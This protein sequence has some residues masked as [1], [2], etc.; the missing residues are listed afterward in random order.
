MGQA[1]QKLGSTG[2][3]KRMFTQIVDNPDYNAEVKN[4]RRNNFYPL[5]TYA[6]F[7][8]S[9]IYLNSNLIDSA[10]VTLKKIIEDQM[11][12]GSAYRLLGNVYSLKGDSILANKYIVRANDQSDFTPPPADNLIDS[13]LTSG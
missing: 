1:Y 11:T 8:L 2:N 7:Q 3:A 6:M 4:T 13:I 9:R 12:Y 5:K 10:E